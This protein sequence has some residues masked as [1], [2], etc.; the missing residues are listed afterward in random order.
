MSVVAGSFLLVFAAV[1]LGAT[2][3]LAK[4]AAGEIG[5]GFFPA[6]CGMLLAGVGA[7]LVGMGLRGTAPSAAAHDR[8]DG[9]GDFLRATAVTGS[10]LLFAVLLKPAGLALALVA[11]I[12]L[13]TRAGSMPPRAAAILSIALGLVLTAFFVAGLRLHMPALPAFLR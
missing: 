11:S 10:V 1:V 3:D 13:S 7:V 12:G 2:A 6:L 5:P 4:L 8:H 9:S